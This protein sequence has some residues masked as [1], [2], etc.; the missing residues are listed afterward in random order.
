VNRG[1]KFLGQPFQL[2]LPR[3]KIDLMWVSPENMSNESRGKMFLS[4][5]EI[6]KL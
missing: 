3:L 6:N 2:L 4:W 5:E 1:I